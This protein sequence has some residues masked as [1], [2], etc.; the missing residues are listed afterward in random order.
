MR[1]VNSLFLAIAL[2]ACGSSQ[3]AD[4]TTTAAAA[5]EP[6]AAPAEAPAEPQAAPVE[7][8]AAPAEAPAAEAPAP[9]PQMNDAQIAAFLSAANKA[10]IDSSQLVKKSGKSADVKKFAAM[11]IKDHQAADKRASGL[12]VKAGIQPDE[13]GPD[14]QALKGKAQPVIDQLK[15][16][17]GAELDRAYVDAQVTMHQDVIDALDQKIMPAV[18]NPELKALVSEIRPKL[19][20]HLDQAKALQAKLGGAAGGGGG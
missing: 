13:S 7:Q 3:D 17:K 18:Q 6:A 9:A 8:P 15:G 19:Q 5:E 2:C 1:T 11:I 4:T 20:G 10:E 16:L 12:L 14:V